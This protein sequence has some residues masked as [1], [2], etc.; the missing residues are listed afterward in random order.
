MLALSSRTEIQSIVEAELSSHRYRHTLAVMHQADELALHYSVDRDAARLAGLLHDFTKEWT[1]EKQLKTIRHSDT[2]TI[3]EKTK[4]L[5]GS[6][7][8]Y[9]AVTGM[10]VARDRFGITDSDLLN[11]IRYHTTARPEM[12]TL[13]KI[14]YIADKTSLDRTY[15]EAESYRALSFQSLDECLFP[16][17]RDIMRLVAERGTPISKE[18][19]DAYRAYQQ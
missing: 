3:E 17:L 8:L 6:P 10:L 18:T 7:T 13:E 5:S 11:S 9:H 12:S 1:V 2:I 14:V 16:L 19:I 4:I 15:P